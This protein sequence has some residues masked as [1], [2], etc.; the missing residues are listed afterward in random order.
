MDCMNYLFFLNLAGRLYIPGGGLPS[1][2]A[3]PTGGLPSVPSSPLLSGFS[4]G[5]LSPSGLPSGFPSV[6][7]FPSGGF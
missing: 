6:S 1:D 4:P 7:G 3:P 5:F 2:A